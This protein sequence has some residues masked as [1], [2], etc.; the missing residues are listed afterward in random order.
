MAAKGAL[1]SLIGV[2]VGSTHI[3]AVLVA[4][5][6]GA[7][8]VARRATVTH[9][10]RGGGAYHRPDEL[11]G[12]VESAIAECVVASG[13]AGAAGSGGARPVAIGIASMAEAGVP[14]D[15]HGRPVGEILA[16]FD[17]RPAP[18]ADWLERRIGAPALFARTGLRPEAKYT[19]PKL[20]W[21]RAERPGDVAR[22]RC[23][24][25]VAELVGHHLTGELATNASLA[26]RTAAFSTADRRWDDELLGLAGLSPDQMPAVLP[27]GRPAGGLT[28]AAAARLGLAAGT[29]VAIAGHDHMAGALGA[30]VTRPGDALD[31]MGSAEVALLVTRRPSLADELRRSGFSSGCHALDGTWYVA[32]GLQASGAL[33]EWF[34]DRFLAPPL[35]RPAAA[36]VTA[37]SGDAG[38]YAAFLALL[39]RAGSGPARPLVRPYLRGR[40]APRRNVSATLEIEGLAESHGLPDLAAALVDGAA[41]HVRWMLEELERVTA[42]TP[43]RVRVIGGGTRNT[44]WL[45]AKAALGPGRFEVARTDEAAALGAALVAGVAGGVYGSVAAALANAAPFERVRVSPGVRARYDAAYRD[46][47]LPAVMATLR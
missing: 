36:L 9:A 27:L 28:P 26:C 45:T 40:T 3:K 44:R 8:H 37:A 2:D 29:P 21:L 30:G 13:A 43:G 31:S 35:D 1:G 20:L 16:W 25:G 6:S 15:V 38:R 32:G 18:Q 5:G 4:P 17:P 23:W 41:F 14:L 39:D 11:L 22:A 34:I 46:R 10:V 33:V 24:A 47:W 7:V 19:L 42:T 12:A